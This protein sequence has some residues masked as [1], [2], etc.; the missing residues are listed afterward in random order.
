MYWN[1][2]TVESCFLHESWYITTRSKFTA[3]CFGVIFL[4]IALE[5]VRRLQREYD[6][7]IYTQWL[8]REFRGANV[9]HESTYD[10]NCS[11]LQKAILTNIPFLT[12]NPAITKKARFTP[13]IFQ[14]LL[15]SVFYSIQLGGSYIVMLLAMYFNGYIY[16][17]ILIGAFLGFLAFGSDT[18]SNHPQHSVDCCN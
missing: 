5:F 8:Q 7:L 2:Y 15:R 9:N 16:F 11:L 14:Q 4:V 13:S 6:K 1:W 3:T 17:S 18:I 10:R 12:H